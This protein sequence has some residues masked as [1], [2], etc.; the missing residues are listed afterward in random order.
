MTFALLVAVVLAAPMAKPGVMPPPLPVTVYPARPSGA[1]RIEIPQLTSPSPLSQYPVPPL[2]GVTLARSQNVRM[3]R[4]MEKLDEARD[5]ALAV[6]QASPHHP[7]LVTELGQ[8]YAARDEWP[9][10]IKLAQTERAAAKD[11][12]LLGQEL[13]EALE[14][15][16]KP[17]EAAQV[18]IDCWA[19][20][21]TTA[22]WAFE[23]ILRLAPSDSKA[24][25][26][27]MRRAA[28]ARPD[29]VDLQTGAAR[30]DW[31]FGDETGAMKTL[32]TADRP[33]FTPPLRWRFADELLGTASPRD[34][35][36][37]VH[38]LESMASDVRFDVSYRMEAAVRA[39][40][41]HHDMG[42]VRQGALAL[43]QALHDV[44]PPRW[45]ADLLLDVARD[46][47]EAGESA[48]ARR[49]LE[50]PGLDQSGPPQVKLER[51]LNELRD[52]PSPHALAAMRDVA[53]SS[54]EARFHYA[55]ALFFAGQPDS[56]LAEY[57]R[58]SERADGAYTGAA[59]DRMFMIEDAN[60][61]SALPDVGHLM[62]LDWRGDPKPVLVMAD[63][64]YR[65]LPHG[66]LWSRVAL[67]LSEKLE[68][69]GQIQAAL[70]PVLAVAEGQPDDRLAPVAR[71]RA[72]DLYVRLKQEPEAISQYE[73]CLTRYPKAWNSAEVRR[74][75]ETLRKKAGS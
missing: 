10:L 58:V 42:N 1:F 74:R 62:Y 27:S 54:D 24:I 73:A 30:L 41:I 7:L 17:R 68:E 35:A 4:R 29:R 48:A 55:E 64:L 38:A 50:S 5:S 2:D 57:K 59:F 11:T 49:L 25:R 40:D 44:P 37:A 8:T 31:K 39:H 6:L 12:L 9:A 15:T 70:A 32:I 53:G 60:P 66:P 65:T 56:A 28:Q 23:D 52:A 69:T 43:E 14:R 72:G 26:E 18:A 21:P 13:A 46:L 22:D 20:E 16:K 67:L 3:L 61:K 19:V 63:S 36:G 51:A 45:N 33:G 47:R 34:S 71:Q 75:L